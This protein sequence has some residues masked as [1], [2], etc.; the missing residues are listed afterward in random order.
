MFI[1]NLTKPK[2]NGINHIHISPRENSRSAQIPMK[3]MPVRGCAPVSVPMV[4]KT[5]TAAN[6]KKPPARMSLR[7]V[8][9][10]Y[11]SSY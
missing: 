1:A 3:N 9:N 2:A 5:K 11:K 4:S 7:A 8:P 10:F 6:P